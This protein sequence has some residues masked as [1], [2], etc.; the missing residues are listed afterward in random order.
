MR[1]CFTSPRDPTA[2]TG[3]ASS[4]GILGAGT[5]V[6]Y[7]FRGTVPDEQ[8]HTF[9][10]AGLNPATRYRL[11]FEDNTAPDTEATGRELMSQGLE[12]HLQHPLSSE[13][14]FITEPAI[15]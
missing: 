5:G 14:V 4:I 9:V 15:P 2:C 7:A 12:L 8:R 11:H 13:L 3:M 6:V 1:S 10:L